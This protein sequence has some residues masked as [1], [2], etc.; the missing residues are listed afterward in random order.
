M[1]AVGN[2]RGWG[3]RGSPPPLSHGTSR[4][5]KADPNG[6]GSDLSPSPRGPKHFMR[7]WES[8]QDTN[9]RNTDGRQRRQRGP[10]LPPSRG[11]LLA[12][13]RPPPGPVLAQQQRLPHD[14]FRFDFS[15]VGFVVFFFFSLLR[16]LGLSLFHF[17]EESWRKKQPR[18]DAEAQPP[19]YHRGQRPL[20]RGRSSGLG[21]ARSCS[22]SGRPVAIT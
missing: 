11:P 19:F 12:F 2:M 7:L 21:R 16:L 4:R 13:T 20:P 9:G 3:R 10:A 14:P 22:G 15:R 17:V 5:L 1:A 8:S 18:E 6:W